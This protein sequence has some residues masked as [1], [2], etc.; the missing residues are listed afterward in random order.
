M[1]RLQSDHSGVE[2]MIV[3]DRAPAHQRRDHRRVRQLCERDQVG[4]GFRV[5]DAAAGDDQ[6]PLRRQQQVERATNRL[7]A[8]ARARDLQRFVGVGI[9]VDDLTLHVDRQIDVHGTR[10]ARAH[11]LEGLAEDV[12]HLRAF[13]H[14]RRPL[15]HGRRDGGDVDRLKIFFVEFRARRLPREAQDRHAVGHRRIETRHHVRS[16]RTGGAD[17]D[18]DAAGAR[19]AVAFGRMRAALFVPHEDVPD[20]AVLAERV[21]ERQNRRAGHAENELDALALHHAHCSFHCRHFG[22]GLGSSPGRFR[23]NYGIRDTV[24]RTLAGPFRAVKGHFSHHPELAVCHPELVEGPSARRVPRGDVRREARLVTGA[25]RQAQDDS[26]EAQADKRAQNHA[27][28]YRH[29]SDRSGIQNTT[30]QQ[31]PATPGEPGGLWCDMPSSAPGQSAR[32][33]EPHSPGPEPRSSSSLAAP[34]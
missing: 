32:L 6:R 9:V 33:L 15:G 17:V 29:K 2:R 16:G 14:R 26:S 10:A 30:Y 7:L 12:R 11:Q 20:A 25:L 22:H 23:L 5:D 27:A 4:G 28:G 13:H 24:F 18:A 1:L 31:R 21:V 34:T 19:A 8:G 3:G